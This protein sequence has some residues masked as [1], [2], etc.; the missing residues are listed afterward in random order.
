[1]VFGALNKWEEVLFLSNVDLRKSPT[2][3]HLHLAMP[4]HYS[5]MFEYH[6]KTMIPHITSCICLPGPNITN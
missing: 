5:R 4:H 6:V 1:M 2:T 3:Y